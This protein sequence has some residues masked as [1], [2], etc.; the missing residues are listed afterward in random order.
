MI[1]YQKRSLVILNKL[2]YG[3]MFPNYNFL[4]LVLNTSWCLLFAE[5]NIFVSGSGKSEICPLRM[6]VIWPVSWEMWPLIQRHQINSPL[7]LSDWLWKHTSGLNIWREWP[8]PTYWRKKHH[9]SSIIEVSMN[10][11]LIWV[12]N[13]DKYMWGIQIEKWSHVL[14]Y[15]L[16]SLIV[17]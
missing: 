11:L 14:C 3:I 10:M 8:S 13:L 5:I 6:A 12:T 7:W 2:L 16:K 9:G 15:T 4:V 1:P 17:D